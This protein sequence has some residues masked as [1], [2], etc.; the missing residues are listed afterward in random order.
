M[1]FDKPSAATII[2]GSILF[3]VAAFSPISRIFGIQDAAQKLDIISAAP[4]QW[5]IAQG[6]F[7]LG[8]I[9]TVAGIGVLAYRLAGQSFSIYLNLSVVVMAIGALLWTWHVYL[10]A[11]DPARFTAGEIPMWLFALYSLL[12]MV[13]LALI[14]IALL[15]MA[16]PSWV[17]WLAIG[18]P[19]LF[20][21]LAL[22]LGDMPPLVYYVVTL[23][24]GTVLYRA[25]LV[26]AGAMAPIG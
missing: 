17:G 19:A 5:M 14:G 18:A 12:T 15:H 24:I 20:L 23:V 8:S 11:F 13:G 26:G 9:V 21:V 1:S 16:L 7:A 4:N 6:L 22:V 10:R 3:L 25:S 2:V